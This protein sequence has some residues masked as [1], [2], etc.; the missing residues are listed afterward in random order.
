MLPERHRRGFTL[1]ELLVVIAI[2]AILAAILFP[3]F[4]RA[5]EKARQ[6]SC[7]SNMKQW[8]LAMMMYAQDY[9]EMLP[10]TMEVDAHGA[11][12]VLSA[13]WGA[14]DPYVKNRQLR[15]CPS[16]PD[17]SDPNLWGSYLMNGMLSAGAR[18]LNA[19]DKPA[20]TILMAERQRGWASMPDND[21]SDPMSPYYDLCYDS[22]LP[23]GNWYTGTI[24]WPPVFGDLLDT[25][26]HNGGQNFAFMDGHAKWMRWNEAV[27]SA[28]DNLHDLH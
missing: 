1:I 26:R 12:T 8:G 13:W 21:P 27:K 9:D 20:E 14:I 10:I 15:W 28:S 19:S 2:I 11:S 23:N 16:D 22:W 4:A 6:A 25:E 18:S 5:R 7:L 24:A 17:K 3:V